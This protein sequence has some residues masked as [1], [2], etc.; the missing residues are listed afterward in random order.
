[1]Y[2]GYYSRQLIVCSLLMVILGII[3]II[4]YNPG[5]Y[6]KDINILNTPDIGIAGIVIGIAAFLIVPVQYILKKLKMCS[7][8]KTREKVD[9]GKYDRHLFSREYPQDIG[10]VRSTKLGNVIRSFEYYAL[11]LYNIDPIT[12]W[13]RLLAIVPQTYREQ[14]D[15]AET[16][17]S[18]FLNLSFFVSILAI[19]SIVFF[20]KRQD[21]VHAGT[22]VV[23]SFLSYILYNNSCKIA[24]IWGEYVRSA[25]DLYRLDLLKQIG[26]FLPPEGIT[27]EKERNIWALVQI[28]TYDMKDPGD[29]LK[30]L[31]KSWEL[32][33]IKP[34]KNTE[35]GI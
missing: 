32:D 14:I 27:L 7:Y 20:I 23:L 5:M 15:E 21:I 18:F 2:E 35:V 17:F 6:L 29:E 8:E 22:F 3:N 25:F 24:A 11:A 10:L 16:N 12:M 19:E 9:N 30:F 33:K 1:M 34:V 4:A 26:V 31:P 13:F 28:A